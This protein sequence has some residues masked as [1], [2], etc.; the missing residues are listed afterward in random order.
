MRSRIVNMP[1][2]FGLPSSTATFDPG[3]SVDGPSVHTIASGVSPIGASGG[4]LGVEDGRGE[5]GDD[6]GD[7]RMAKS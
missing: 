2:V 3:G 4:V 7:V 5:E 6:E 1:S